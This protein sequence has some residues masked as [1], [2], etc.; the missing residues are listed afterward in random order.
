[1]TSKP[2]FHVERGAYDI[3]IQ[4]HETLTNQLPAGWGLRQLGHGKAPVGRRKATLGQR[5]PWRY[6]SHVILELRDERG[7]KALRYVKDAETIPV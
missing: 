4:R 3:P 6:G 5:P 7:R 1:M 2:L